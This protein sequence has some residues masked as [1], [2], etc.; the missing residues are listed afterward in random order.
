MPDEKNVIPMPVQALYEGR[1]I[2]RVEN[3]RLKTL[4]VAIVG[5]YVDYDGGQKML[6]RALGV[7]EGDILLTTQLPRAITG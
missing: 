5:D 3:R 1:R 4:S 6:V 2:Y 7:S